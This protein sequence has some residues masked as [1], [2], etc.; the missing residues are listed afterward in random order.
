MKRSIDDF[1]RRL[2]RAMGFGTILVW[3]SFAVIF[4][5]LVMIISENQ[6]KLAESRLASALNSFVANQEGKLAIIAS[7]PEFRTFLR[8]GEEGQAQL[9]TMALTLLSTLRDDDLHGLSLVSSTNNQTPIELGETK[10]PT[11]GFDLCYIGDNLNAKF[12][13]CLATVLLYYNDAALAKV[14]AGSE[15][16]AWCETCQTPIERFL[17]DTPFLRLSEKTAFTVHYAP[18]SSN[19]WTIQTYFVI[20]SLLLVGFGIFFRH[21]VGQSIKQDIIDPLNALLSHLEKGTA[22]ELS[23]SDSI[24]EFFSIHRHNSALAAVARTT[25]MLAHDVRKPFN[26]F[27][28]TLDTIKSAQCDAKLRSL[29]SDALPDIERSLASVN[30]LISDVMNV[31]A[32][33]PLTLTPLRLAPVV[34]EAREDLAKLFPNRSLAFDIAVPETLWVKAD[35]ARLP[36]VFH[37]L[38]SNAV[39]A[40]PTGT[41]R[42]WIR[43]TA[44]S[45]DSGLSSNASQRRVTLSIGNLGSF[46][47][48]ELR[49]KMFDLFASSGKL[50]GTGLGLAIVKKIIAGHGSEVRCTSVRNGQ[51]PDGRVEFTMTLEEAPE[52]AAEP[53]PLPKA[54]SDR[55]AGLTPSSALPGVHPLVLVLDDSLVVRRAWE[56]KLRKQVQVMSFDGPKALEHALASGAVELGHVHTVITDH[57]F[58]PGETKTGLDVAALLRKQ[59]FA[60]TILL[61]SNG[62]FSEAEV[63]GVVDKVI[64]K[65]PVDWGQLVGAQGLAP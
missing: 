5:S 47:P 29:L 45:G 35:P 20:L 37:N 19:P 63:A 31:D 51:Y 60:G 15:Q 48:E 14:L 34:D 23:K 62:E 30:G 16:I 38:L 7:H 3:L 33:T 54:T 46:V 17:T 13:R 58:A 59:G 24:E 4:Q 55:L 27:R 44:H 36:R 52:P 64:D 22:P 1:R 12:G 26:L 28:M 8:S 21:L 39:E 61:S 40:V 11:L 49:E 6:T 50:G 32:Q 42:L 9:Q 10:G 2:T 53:G 57:F 25:Q 18:A 41:V 65:M 43:A 56:A